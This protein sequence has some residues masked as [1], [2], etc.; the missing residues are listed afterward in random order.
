MRASHVVPVILATVLAGWL[1]G[2][3]GTEPQPQPEV[4]PEVRVTAGTSTS[5]TGTVGT[6]VQP[7]P[8][9]RATDEH[10]RPLAGVAITFKVVSGGGTIGG[11]TVTTAPD[12]SAALGKWTLGPTPGTQTLS[13]GAGGQADVVFTALASA[14][15]VAQI[16]PTSGNN[17]L[18][19]VGQPLEQ[20]LVALAADAFGNL[21]AGIPVVF[22]VAAGGGTIAGD[23]VL[24]DSTGKATARPWTLGAE[25]GVQQV[26]AASGAVQA[27]FR[28]FAAAPPGEL[29]GQIAF[30]SF[31]NVSNSVD[32]DM[33][34]INADGSGFR[35]LSYPE[36]SFWGGASAPPAWSPD[37]SLIAFTSVHGGFEVEGTGYDSLRIGLMTSD[38]ATLSWLTE[39]PFDRSPAWSPD[40]TAIAF[41]A[42]PDLA[43]LSLADSRVTVLVPGAYDAH[44]SWSPDG[45]KLAFDTWLGGGYEDIYT[46][47]ADGTGLTPLTTEMEASHPAWSPDGSMIAFVYR[48]PSRGDTLSHVAVMA[49]DGVFLKD[50][51]SAGRIL[52]PGGSGSG[53]IAWS[54]DGR[55]IAYTFEGCD[56][57]EPVD[58]MK[59]IKYVSLDGSR[60]ETIINNAQSPTW[61]R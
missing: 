25:A 31:F 49:A 17:Q 30:L 33:A 47:N 20:P 29:Q 40:G 21:V 55:G 51:A 7:A 48:N 32:I 3:D 9:V 22:T 45:R 36:V 18:A 39:G 35:R 60:Q 26:T 6:E 41:M 57:S 1:Q 11:G 10:G 38:G 53:S 24:T 42:G 56:P 27:A 34:V 15:P 2:C 4:Q 58:C 50:L 14:G 5:V 13:A 37:G 23:P 28:A 8:S 43:S 44:P 54:P 52:Y 19:G 61:R 16:T 59:S 46:V 12:G